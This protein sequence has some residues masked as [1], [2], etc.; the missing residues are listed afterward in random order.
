M[1]VGKG[2]TIR[3]DFLGSLKEGDPVVFDKGLV[4]SDGKKTKVGAPYLEGRVVGT[5]VTHGRDKKV[6][7]YKKKRRTDYHK[8]L[9]HKQRF[10]S[11]RID[12]IEA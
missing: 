12:S 3:V 5:V 4:V 11:V 10:T 8:M 6:I 2:E 9:G 1:R 7:V